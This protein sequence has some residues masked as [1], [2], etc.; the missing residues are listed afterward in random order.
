MGVMRVLADHGVNVPNEI[1]VVGYDGTPL[2]RIGQRE[3][4]TV[5]QTWSRSPDSASNAPLHGWT[6]RCRPDSDVVL[7]PTLIVSETTGPP[8]R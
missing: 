4:T 8:P 3:L 2:A 6:A 5:H 1:S 7:S